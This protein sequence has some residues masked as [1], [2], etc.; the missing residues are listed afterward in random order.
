MR[1][2]NSSKHHGKGKRGGGNRGHHYRNVKSNRNCER[3][4]AQRESEL[5]SNSGSE[6]SSSSESANIDKQHGS[7]PD[8][9]IAMWD[10]NQCDPKKCSGRKLARLGLIENLRLGQKFAG[11]VLTPVGESCVSPQDRD[12]VQTSGVA[13]VDCSWAKLDETPFSRMKSPNPRLLPFLVA[14][15][16]IN[17]GKPCKLSCVEAIA[18]TLYI[19]GFISEAEWYMGKFSWGHSFL[20]LNETLLKRYAACKTS[21]EIVHVQNTYISEEQEARNKP[22]DYKEFYPTSSSSSSDEDC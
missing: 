11:L 21:E 13:V 15:N 4:L 7:A 8:F 6:D 3:S 9:P 1:K 2:M 12:I 22:K 17:Y 20:E 5:A 19:C 10:L 14:A 16:P 18:A